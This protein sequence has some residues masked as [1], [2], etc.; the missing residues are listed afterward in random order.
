MTYRHCGNSLG[1]PLLTGGCGRG[2]TSNHYSIFGNTPWGKPI[3]WQFVIKITDG[4][5]QQGSHPRNTAP[6]KEFNQLELPQ[7]QLTAECLLLCALSHSSCN[8]TGY[9]LF[10]QHLLCPM[11]PRGA[12]SLSPV[13]LPAPRAA[14]AKGERGSSK[15]SGALPNATQWER[16]VPGHPQVCL[17]TQASC[18]ATLPRTRAL[19]RAGC[20]G[21]AGQSAEAGVDLGGDW[22]QL[23]VLEKS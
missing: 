16:G 14:R 23:K 17:I 2:V 8:N 12:C 21:L 15:R 9:C 6:G 7:P 1:P 11:W 18:P 20:G 5:T 3:E 13:T 10:L 4:L 19:I 22:S